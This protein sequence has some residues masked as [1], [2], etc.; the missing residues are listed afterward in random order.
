MT[1]SKR[2]PLRKAG[3]DRATAQDVPDT[4]Q[5]RAPA[6]RLA[7]TDDDFMCPVQTLLGD[8]PEVRVGPGDSAQPGIAKLL[9]PPM[10]GDLRPAVFYSCKIRL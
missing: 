9:L 4:P 6:Y 10:F 1:E 5:T 8:L 3:D 7:F 2:H